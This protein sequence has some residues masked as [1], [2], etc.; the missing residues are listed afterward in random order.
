MA[1]CKHRGRKLRAAAE[2]RADHRLKS[3]AG[4]ALTINLSSAAT[5]WDNDDQ[6]ARHLDFTLLSL[7]QVTGASYRI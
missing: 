1:A 5:A 6:R 7:M 3:A 4:G 2:T